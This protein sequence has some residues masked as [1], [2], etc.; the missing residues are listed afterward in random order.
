M[1]SCLI[2]RHRRSMMNTLSIQRP[3][4]IHGDLH[5]GGLPSYLATLVGVEDGRAAKAE[6]APPLTP[7]P[8]PVRFTGAQSANLESPLSR[9]Q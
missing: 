5:A 8:R 2:E 7:R 3:A 9:P 6:R 4:P 1:S